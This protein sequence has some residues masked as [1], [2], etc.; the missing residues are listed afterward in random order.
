MDIQMPEMDGYA[1]TSAIRA[2]EKERGGHVPI[3]AMTAH[4]MAADRE[5]ALAAGMD[6]Y[7]TKPITADALVEVIN[8]HLQTRGQD[9]LP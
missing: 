8:R 3:I 1:T 7:L 9:R 2:M 6:D 5:R 4:A